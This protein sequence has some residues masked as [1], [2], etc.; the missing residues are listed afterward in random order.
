MALIKTIGLTVYYDEDNLCDLWPR[1]LL[2]VLQ[3]VSSVEQPCKDFC[4]STF[5]HSKFRWT[6]RAQHA[7]KHIC[8][9]LIVIGSAFRGIPEL[10]SGGVKI[11]S[12]H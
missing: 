8:M 1:S 7:A 2:M 3:I 9:L 11:L 6:F 5:S 12:P 10:P 4:C